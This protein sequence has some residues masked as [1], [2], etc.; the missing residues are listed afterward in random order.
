MLI[1]LNGMGNQYWQPLHRNNAIRATDNLPHPDHL[2]LDDDFYFVIDNLQFCCDNIN[3][4]IQ[5]EVF[6]PSKSSDSC[7]GQMINNIISLRQ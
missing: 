7:S 3:I 2:D 5:Q 1:H 6:G 4:T